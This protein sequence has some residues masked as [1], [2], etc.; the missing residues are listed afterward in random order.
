MNGLG[1]IWSPTTRRCN[2][3]CRFNKWKIVG[4]S[5]TRR[6]AKKAPIIAQNIAQNGALVNK[7]IW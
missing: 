5:V 6:L 3:I 7:N 1:Y 2:V 4:N